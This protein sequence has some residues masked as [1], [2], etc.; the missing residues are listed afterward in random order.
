M[1]TYL[2]QLNTVPEKDVRR[3]VV[4]HCMNDAG[5][6]QAKVVSDEPYQTIFKVEYKE[7][8]EAD[9]LISR[10]QQVKERLDDKCES[11]H[12]FIVS[13]ELDI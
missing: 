7:I 12:V 10:L 5:F 11:I 9:K 3:I 8:R 4:A 1:Y 13:N 2:I 6:G